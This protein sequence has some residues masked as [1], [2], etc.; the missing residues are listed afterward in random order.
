MYLLSIYIYVY[1]LYIH[2]LFFI[3]LKSCSSG[4]RETPETIES[5]LHLL[6]PQ[7]QAKL[8]KIAA[9]SMSEENSNDTSSFAMLGTTVEPLTS[10]Y[11]EFSTAE[12]GLNETSNAL[13]IPD[14]GSSLDGIPVLARK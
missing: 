4:R 7:H 8:N 3:W 14:L 12:T 5:K 9:G 6:K 11:P 2:I 13:H 1:Y 10:H